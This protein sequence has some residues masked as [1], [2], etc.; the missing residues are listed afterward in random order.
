MRMEVDVVV[1][2]G[3]LG[4]LVKPEDE[5][6]AFNITGE[7]LMILSSRVSL[8]RL[9]RYRA[10]DITGWERHDHHY[11]LRRDYITTRNIFTHPA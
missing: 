2:E 5:V 10:L 9:D 8:L 6:D 1:D 3:L 11:D 4:G 7:C